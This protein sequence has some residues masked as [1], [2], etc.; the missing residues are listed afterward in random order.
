M[1]LQTDRDWRTRPLLERAYNSAISH[2]PPSKT[3][4]KIL[5]KTRVFVLSEP[6]KQQNGCVSQCVHETASTTKIPR[7]RDSKCSCIISTWFKLYRASSEQSLT[8]WPLQKPHTTRSP[9]HHIRKQQRTFSQSVH[10]HLPLKGSQNQT[11]SN[12]H[13]RMMENMTWEWDPNFGEDLM[14]KLEQIG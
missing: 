7:K 5:K 14:D 11:G 12:L 4:E 8:N 10:R 2:A 1:T 13:Q 3:R 6:K 9:R